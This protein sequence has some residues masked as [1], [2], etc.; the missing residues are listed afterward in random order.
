MSEKDYF[1]GKTAWITG[2]SSGIGE[3]L[4]K[5]LAS[6][7]AR[8]IISSNDLEGLEQTL[9]SMQAMGAN[10]A[11][12]PFNLSDPN[13]V[14]QAADEVLDKYGSIDFLFNNGGVSQRSTAIETPLSI[15]RKIMEV[16]FFSGLIL[17]KKLLPAMI[18]NGG[19]HI[20][21]T[22]SISGLFGFPLRSAYSASKHA[23]HGFYESV[24]TELHDK[25]IRTTLVCPGRVKTNI[26]LN[27]LGLDGNPHGKMD[28]GQAQGISPE[29]CARKILI[30]VMKNRRQVLVGG[31]ELLLA[32]IKQFLP[33]LFYKLVTRI[34]PT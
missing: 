28:Q 2:G 34:K 31:N 11:S 16:N 30:A 10:V 14:E 17:T 32:R 24:W 7:G 18:K 22:S 9:G 5:R 23:M 8:V 33:F 27:A 4:A 19:G 29:E 6:L 13:E 3:A 25:G 12:L 15:D 20:I 26:S 21:A 1:K